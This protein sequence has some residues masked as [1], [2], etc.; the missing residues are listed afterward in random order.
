MTDRPCPLDRCQATLAPG[1]VI[2]G[3]CTNRTRLDLRCIP[4]LLRELDT[5]IAKLTSGGDGN[6]LGEVGRLDYDPV[7]SQARTAL[8]TVLHGWARVWDEETPRPP[9]VAGPTCYG[10]HFVCEHASCLAVE[11]HRW[12]AE[13]DARIAT[14]AGQATLLAWLP[15]LGSRPWAAE[16]ASEVRAAVEQGWRAVDRPPDMHFIGWCPDCEG[17]ALYAAEGA[18]LTK[19]R[20]CGQAYDVAASKDALLASATTQHETATVIARALRLDPALIRQWRRRGRLEPVGC[21]PAGQPLYRVSDVQALRA[22]P[23]VSP[24]VDATVTPTVLP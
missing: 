11:R 5:A 21:N 7:A 2:C 19:C 15:A 4:E 10:A 14:P 16:L 20:M 24:Q 13:Q 17:T 1:Q 23:S 12:R 9:E 6:A 3:G 18:A 22:A 8:L